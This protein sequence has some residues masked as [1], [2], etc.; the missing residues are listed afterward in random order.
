MSLALS[1]TDIHKRY[2]VGVAGCQASVSA[3][4]GVSLEVQRAEIVV[5]AGAAGS[6]KSTLLL[7]A[8]GLLR[9]DRG[10]IHWFGQRAPV[11]GRPAG[12]MYRS[13]P[14]HYGCLHV[15][16][17]LLHVS[18]RNF[19]AMPNHGSARLALDVVGLAAVADRRVA[20]LTPAELRRLALA[21]V[22]LVAPRLALLDEPA[23][24][25]DPGGEI[26]VQGALTALAAR[27]TTLV[28]TT[29]HPRVLASTA[30][31][32][33]ALR[34]GRLAPPPM[35]VPRALE[36]TVDQAPVVALRLG[37]RRPARSAG[38][39]IVRVAL[40]GASPEEVLSE[41]RQLGI[42]VHASRVVMRGSM[43]AAR[44]AEDVTPLR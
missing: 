22:L 39:T 17:S 4:R 20:T 5:V 11:T 38:P 12:V 24:P 2:R 16:E 14:T 35:P 28:V 13:V 6:G 42:A 31:R 15:L 18:Q 41:C 27:G 25:N 37:Q 40:G 9:P 43:A 19:V 23:A 26:L 33:L 21:E 32:V 30:S 7:C 36:L 8:A 1:L 34:D 44:V 10:L 29:A 3:L